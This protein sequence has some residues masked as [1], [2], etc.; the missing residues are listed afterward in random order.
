MIKVQATIEPEEVVSSDSELQTP[1]KP[2]RG[3]K[4]KSQPE[5]LEQPAE[6]PAETENNDPFADLFDDQP[7]ALSVP[8]NANA[9]APHPQQPDT[10][11]EPAAAP[12]PADDDTDDTD[13]ASD[14]DDELP[15]IDDPEIFDPPPPSPRKQSADEFIR[16]Q[17]SKMEQ[18]FVEASLRLQELHD[19]LASTKSEIKET[20]ELVQSLAYDL[21]QLREEEDHVGSQMLK[22]GL[23]L[24]EP[25]WWRT[26]P[27]EALHLEKIPGL[28]VKK[29]EALTERIKTIGELETIRAKYGSLRRIPGLGEQV[30]AALEDRLLDWLTQYRDKRELFLA[31]QKLKKAEEAARIDPDTET[32]PLAVPHPGDTTELVIEAP[33]PTPKPAEP[34]EP[35]EPPKPKRKRKQAAAEQ[36]AQSAHAPEPRHAE[37]IELAE[38][39]SSPEHV[40]AVR[41]FAATMRSSYE[42]SGSTALIPS[43]EGQVHWKQGYAAYAEGK[44]VESCPFTVSTAQMNW[45]RGWIQADVEAAEEKGRKGGETQE[46]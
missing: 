14:A 3:R 19:S 40:E 29:R 12:V 20:T 38:D 2:K 21:K 44:P 36:P 35:A 10:K 4:R 42:K 34:A 6:Q 23:N 1:E 37:P 9:L 33:Q 45:L 16:A 22:D 24:A 17:I 27:I 30:S 46:A 41:K 5:V 8:A 39:T 11:P 32:L 28:G 18:A 13:D 31:A 26:A 25:G 15:E 43:L 7:A